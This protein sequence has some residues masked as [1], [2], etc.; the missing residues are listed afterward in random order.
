MHDTWDEVFR[1][2]KWGSYAPLQLLEWLTVSGWC[3]RAAREPVLVL[4]LGC[5]TGATT[6]ALADAGFYVTGI[7]ESIEAVKQANK[8]LLDHDLAEVY[9]MDFHQV[10]GHF[11]PNT[12]DLVIDVCSLQHNTLPMMR[13]IVVGV[14]C[15]M[16]PKAEFWSMMVADGTSQEIYADLP[17][18]H[19]AT[20]E[21]V[22]KIFSPFEPLFVSEYIRSDSIPDP[23][24]KRSK[25]PIDASW[26]DDK[27][28][29]VACANSLIGKK[30]VQSIHW[31]VSC[32]KNNDERPS[33]PVAAR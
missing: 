17:F 31:I 30:T 2:K 24:D 16:K 15:V 8:N 26:P 3:A 27:R 7:D 18:T 9:C 29:R 10:P 1:S 22:K 13:D 33:T 20:E 28:F 32:R 12:F 4:E 11:P 23:E 19:F 14:K 25:T 6:K 5:A 21:D